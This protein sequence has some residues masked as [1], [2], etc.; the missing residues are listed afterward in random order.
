MEMLVTDKCLIISIS[1]CF[2]L[3]KTDANLLKN[4][5]QSGYHKSATKSRR[6]SYVDLSNRN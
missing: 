1:R 3:G 2:I 4:G 6:Y 5:G